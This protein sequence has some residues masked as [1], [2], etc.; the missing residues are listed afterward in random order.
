M[1]QSWMRH[2]SPQMSRMARS[3]LRQP[4]MVAAIASVAVHGALWVV[5]PML[6]SEAARDE[7]LDLPEPVGMVELTAEDLSRLPDFSASRLPDLPP[8]LPNSELPG[9]DLPDIDALEYED[10]DW[11]SLDDLDEDFSN[12]D[13][14]YNVP[15]VPGNPY[16]YRSQNPAPSRTQSTQPPPSPPSTDPTEPEATPNDAPETAPDATDEPATENPPVS[17]YTGDVADLPDLNPSDPTAA[18]PEDESDDNTPIAAA[19]TTPAT[20]DDEMTREQL[21]TYSA[22]GT[23]Q[24]DFLESNRQFI[25]AWIPELEARGAADN[26]PLAENVIELRGEAPPTTCLIDPEQL[27]QADNPLAATYGVMVD[28]SGQVIEGESPGTAIAEDETASIGNP[29]VV[30]RSGFPL[31]DRAGRERVLDYE[32]DATG[33]AQMYFVRTTFDFNPERCQ[34][35]ANPDDEPDGAI[36]DEPDNNPGEPE[37][38]GPSNRPED[39]E[40]TQGSPDEDESDDDESDN[41]ESAGSAA[42]LMPTDNDT[43]ATSEPS[44]TNNTNAE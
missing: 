7:E 6:P 10:G 35:L 30:W 15:S 12:Y 21:L 31:L 23:T 13:W 8:N 17:E 11:Y 34:E 9:S 20:T 25:T 43:G 32:F 3:A 16:N 22:V 4:T 42:D 26:L 33:E 14:Y 1:V 18:A 38:D 44:E 41:D 36:A 39:G 27:A 37:N 28:A 5:L 24:G 40:P 29:E 2:V 19:P